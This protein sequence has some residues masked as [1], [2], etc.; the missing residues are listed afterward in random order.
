MTRACSRPCARIA[1]LP[2]VEPPVYPYSYGVVRRLV[3]LLP[4]R[5][6][7]HWK[8]IRDETA[9]LD[10]L[11]LVVTPGETQGLEDVRIPTR[12]WFAACRPPGARGDLEFLVLLLER[13]GLSPALQAHLFERCDLPLRY[14]GPPACAI[15][16]PAPRIHYQR[17]PIQRERCAIEPVIRQPIPTPARGGQ[18]VIDVALLALCARTLEIHPLIYADPA[19][20]RVADCG[21]G[22][23]VALIGVRREFRSPLETLHVFLVV[24]N[25]VPVAYGP[26]AVF[27][28]C[29]ELGMNLFPGFRGGEVRWLYAQL[30][31]VLHHVLAVD[32]FFVTR[33]GIGDGNDEAIESGAF[34]FYRRLGFRPTSARVETLAR[35]EEA[36]MAARPGHRSDRRT[37]RRL[38]HTEAALDLSNGRCRPMDLGR[39]GVAQSRFIAR[40]FS[41]DRALSERRCVARV[42]RLLGPG[43]DG[44][45]LRALSPLLCMIP[46]LPRW[47]GRERAALARIVRAKDAPCEIP[48]ARRFKRH[49]RLEAALRVLAER[50]RGPSRG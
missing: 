35:E 46:D 48:A 44:W 9:L 39:L 13:S 21:R 5:L 29:C 49:G 41:G 15:E 12:D 7:I 8:A 25:G 42:K 1:A 10:T 22:V 37:L 45:A 18:A 26:A 32:H 33:Y 4:R 3:R 23:R 47:S 27:M 30:M 28:G 11:D 19:G 6:D 36:R 43:G 20:V 31:R 34:W 40:A 17:S 24:K 2:A 16:L 14:A 50:E 38:S